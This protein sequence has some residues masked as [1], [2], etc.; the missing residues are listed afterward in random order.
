MWPNRMAL[1]LQHPC[2]VSIVGNL[3]SMEILHTYLEKRGERAES[4]ETGGEGGDG[5]G[6]SV[7]YLFCCL[8]FS[9]GKDQNKNN[10]RTHKCPAPPAHTPPLTHPPT[11]HRSFLGFLLVSVLLF[12]SSLNTNF[13]SDFQGPDALRLFPGPR[14]F[15]LQDVWLQV[16]ST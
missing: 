9:P 4:G 15:K 14:C 8:G 10:K 2:L 3:P 16:R 12:S 7:A 6:G 1:G 5:R 13:F 11:I